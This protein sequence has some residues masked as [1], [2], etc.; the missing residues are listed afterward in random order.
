MGLLKREAPNS[1]KVLRRILH[2]DEIWYW[3]PTSNEIDKTTNKRIKKEQKREKKERA[4]TEKR[5]KKDQEKAEKKMKKGGRAEPSASRKALATSDDA[6][7]R[8]AEI[9]RALT[10][11]DEITLGNPTE[12]IEQT[13]GIKFVDKNKSK[14]K[15]QALHQS[16]SLPRVFRKKGNQSS[17]SSSS[18][19]EDDTDSDDS[20]HTVPR[21]VNKL[22]LVLRHGTKSSSSSTNTISSTTTTTSFF[23]SSTLSGSACSSPTSSATNTPISSPRP[24]NDGA[25]S[26]VI[27]P[28]S[29]TSDVTCSPATSPRLTASSPRLPTCSPRSPTSDSTS[30]PMSSPRLT[31]TPAAQTVS[32]RG[33]RPL[34]VQLDAGLRRSLQT[35]AVSPVFS[36]GPTYSPRNGPNDP[37]SPRTDPENNAPSSPISLRARCP[38]PL[39]IEQE[40]PASD[41]ELELQSIGELTDDS[42]DEEGAGFWVR[43]RMHRFPSSRIPPTPYFDMILRSFDDCL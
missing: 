5:H 29:P 23:D 13:L 15:S 6:F 24:M 14:A 39:S 19:S 28:R 25:S 38:T 7:W 41:D 31:T 1:E 30:S 11:S 26:P 12:A 27:S 34:R 22:R 10:K 2:Q 20:M 40:E 9:N 35:G 21:A 37:A 18:S 43:E 33:N 3:D 32:P 16:L 42:A 36:N 17:A 4:K 8:K